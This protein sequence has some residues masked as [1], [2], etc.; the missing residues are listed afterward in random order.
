MTE[1]LLYTASN[2]IE[3]HLLQ[4]LLGGEGIQVRL[5]SDLLMGAVGDL[6]TEV[7]QVR[8][9]CYP[10]H[11]NA[12]RQVLENYFKSVGDDWFCGQCGEHNGGAFE[13]CWHC[14]QPRKG[15]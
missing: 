14:R 6:P 2:T 11:L 5:D 13:F 9:W 1:S 12:A 4:G 15:N 8:L 3:A 10:Y 7:Q